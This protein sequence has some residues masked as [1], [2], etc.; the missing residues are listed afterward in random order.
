[1]TDCPIPI[2]DSLGELLIPISLKYISLKF[3]PKSSTTLCHSRLFIKASALDEAF[4]RR[5]EYRPQMIEPAV[6]L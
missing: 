2:R 5:D 3:F 4:N 6:A 1:M